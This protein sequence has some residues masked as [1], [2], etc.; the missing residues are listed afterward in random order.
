MPLPLVPILATAG[1]ALFAGSQIDDALESG[2]IVPVDGGIY[3]PTS[4]FSFSNLLKAG[5]VAGIA[6]AGYTVLK[7]R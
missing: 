7:G 4:L 6:F 2:E 1:I 3:T 5:M